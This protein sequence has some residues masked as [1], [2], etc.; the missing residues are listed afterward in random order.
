MRVLLIDDHPLILTALHT[1]VKGLGER[2]DVVCVS[3]AQAARDALA[4]NPDFDIALLDLQLGEDDGFELLR[5][6]RGLHPALPVVIVTASDHRDDV[7]RA[8]DLGAMGF[9][10]K[11]TANT[12]LMDALRMV[13]SGGVYLP[14]SVMRA[15]S[16][17]RPRSRDGHAIDGDRPLESERAALA[18]EALALTPRQKE[19]LAFLLRGQSNKVIARAL[20]LSVETIKDHVAAVLRA[21]KVSSRTQAVVAVSKM[22]N[23]A[24]FSGWREPRQTT[25]TTIGP[26]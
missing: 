13:L 24:A 25:T 12:M 17:P 5:E 4:V 26:G 16:Q 2:V 10:P 3:K 19:V 7:I 20:N 8:I 6:L 1:L 18:L 21:L 14:P 15:P 11:F 9:V 23:P 22:T